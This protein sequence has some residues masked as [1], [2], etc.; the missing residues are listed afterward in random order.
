[1]FKVSLVLQV[2]KVRK[3]MLDQQGLQAAQAQL[4]LVGQLD[5]REVLVQQVL[6]DLQA[7]QV[8]L[9]PPALLGQQAQLVMV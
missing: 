9:E 3:E 5:Q 7:Q 2:R 8:V 6:A 1:M 4:V